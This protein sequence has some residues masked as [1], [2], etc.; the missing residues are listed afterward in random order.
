MEKSSANRPSPEIRFPSRHYASRAEAGESAGQLSR[1]A[2]R[3]GSRDCS[4]PGLVGRFPPAACGAG[5]QSVAACP[6][7]SSLPKGSFDSDRATSLETFPIRNGRSDG[8]SPDEAG[9]LRNGAARAC[10]PVRSAREKRDNH[11]NSAASG[12]RIE[13]SG[14]N[15]RS[16]YNHS[17]AGDNRARAAEGAVSEEN[18][19]LFLAN[20]LGVS[21]N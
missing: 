1:A 17:T 18:S 12:S 5:R 19:S 2:E 10:W 21:A 8:P 15:G 6:T 7:R 3:F 13:G 20:A 4:R 9:N 11:E 14:S 16:V